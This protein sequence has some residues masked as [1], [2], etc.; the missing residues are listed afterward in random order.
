MHFISSNY[1]ALALYTV[2][3]VQYTKSCCFTVN[4]HKCSQMTM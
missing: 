4:I 3:S 1:A 2:N